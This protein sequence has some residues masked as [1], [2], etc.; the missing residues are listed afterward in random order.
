MIKR[1]TQL[2]TRSFV[3]FAGLLIAVVSA[4][5]LASPNCDEVKGCERKF[6]EIERQI[7]V[8]QKNNNTR[9]ES[10]LRK[11]LEE[12]KANCTDQGL[13]KDLI[14]DI[15]DAKEDIAEYQA[16]LTESEQDADA[17]KVRKYQ[18]KIEEKEKEIK[19][20]KDELS[21]FP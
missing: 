21:L 20:L 4:P 2:C 19:H 18:D 6:C 16:D 5:A 14:R 11:A 12:A 13:R 7:I 3:I 17:K 10:G 8:A 9:R 15:E 1:F